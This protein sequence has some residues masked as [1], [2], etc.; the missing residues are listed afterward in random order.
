MEVKE[1]SEIIQL[2][3][4][5]P[6]EVVSSCLRGFI[7]A[8]PGK[9]LVGADFSSIEARVLA[10][11]AKEEKVLEVFRTHGKIYEK[12]AA[13]IYSVP[14]DKVSKDQRQI[15]KV[16]VLALGYGGGKGAFQSMANAYGVKVS[17]DEAEGIKMRWRATNPRIVQFWYDLEDAAKAA[18]E[19]KQQIKLH[20]CDVSYK[21]A[22]S[23]LFC[24]LPSG[25]VIAYPYPKVE[26]K[27][28]RWG[29]EAPTITFMG[30]DP[31]T[32]KWVRMDTYGGSLCENVVQAV[33]R[34]ILAESLFLLRREGFNTVLHV[35]DEV[36]CEIPLSEK[37]NCVER[38]EELMGVVPAWAT[39]L[40]LKAE[41]NCDTRYWK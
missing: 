33:A 16:A 26:M 12:A 6:M 29:T 1:A 27:M 2:T 11:L 40:P 13:E 7:A 15:G 21:V 37:E 30:E 31:L 23:F 18:I 41:G 4:G 17:D 34:D 39:G 22:G 19:T 20:Q 38:L 25:R 28:K 10:W 35:H 9:I 32:R 14:I 24:R 8:P 3:Y 36:L 5:A